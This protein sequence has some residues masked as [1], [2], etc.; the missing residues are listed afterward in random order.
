MPCASLRQDAVD[1]L[2]RKRGQ[3][4]GAALFATLPRRRSGGYL[5]LLVAYQVAWD[6]LDSISERG[7]DAG[8]T[9]GRQLHLALIDAVEPG[10]PVRDYYCHNPWRDD[11]GYLQALVRSSRDCCQRLPAYS[12][13]RELVLRDGRRAQ[14]LA[15]NHDPVAA[16]RDVA[17]EAW[18]VCEFPT[19]HEATWF[20]LTGAASAGLAAFALLALACEPECR[21]E[22]IAST[23][24]A[25]FPWTSAV[26]CMLDS[27][28]DRDE[29][30][31]NGDHSYIAHY[32]PPEL[33]ITQICILL[34]RCLQTLNG[35]PNGEAH[36][37]IA[38]SMV[39]LYL[40]KDGCRRPGAR[41]GTRRIAHAGGTLTK[42][43]LPVLRLWRAGHALQAS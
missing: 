19:G 9:N 4:D 6:F 8:V 33:A 17:L 35:L 21:D 2:A 31:A 28:A 12:R 26:A 11:G 40:S 10:G 37:V 1:A 15:Y 43:F 7:A 29:D 25:Y 27:Y 24:A 13:V 16:R 30:A 32:G 42:T 39:A 38:S 18:A 20:E 23:H 34:R 3:T 36:L 41:R 22:R 14:V 5:R